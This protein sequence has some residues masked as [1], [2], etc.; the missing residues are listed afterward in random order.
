MDCTAVLI[1]ESN[2]RNFRSVVIFGTF[3]HKEGRLKEEGRRKKIY[4][5][6][7]LDLNTSNCY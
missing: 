6:L 1:S 2:V 7:N 3:M 5:F 4:N